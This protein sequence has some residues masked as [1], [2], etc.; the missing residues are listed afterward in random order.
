MAQSE[1][2][3]GEALGMIE[4]R[5]LVALMGPNHRRMKRPMRW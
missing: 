4:T 5:G 3:V 1:E 2:P